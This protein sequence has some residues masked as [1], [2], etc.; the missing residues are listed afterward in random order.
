MKLLNKIIG[1]RIDGIGS[2]SDLTMRVITIIREEG[3]HTSGGVLR[4]IVDK[5]CKGK[6]LMPIVLMI[7]AIYS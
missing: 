4:I 2:H 3:R 5:F 6:E 7:T 1:C